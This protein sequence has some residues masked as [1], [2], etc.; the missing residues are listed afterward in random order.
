MADD[1]KIEKRRNELRERSRKKAEERTVITDPGSIQRSLGLDPSVPTVPLPPPGAKAVPTED[2]ASTGLPED[3]AGPYLS[4]PASAEERTSGRR[5]R[6]R[7]RFKP[8]FFVILLALIVIIIAVIRAAGSSSSN[9][10]VRMTD[11]G[12]THASRYANCAVINGIDVSQ[13]QGTGIN[14]KQ[15]KTSGADFVFIRAGFRDAEDGSLNKDEN[16][17]TN[18]K[19]ASKAGLM[20]GAYFYSQALTP[21]EAREEADYLTDLVSNY[22]I[23][24]PLVIDYEIYPGGR[25]EQKIDAGELYAASFYH[26]IVIAFCREVEASGYESAVYANL[27]MFTNYMDAGLLQDS[28]TLWLARYNETADL[29]ANYMF[30][31]CSNSA[32][33][34]G[35]EGDVDHDFWYIEPGKVYKT[36]G[37]SDTDKTRI[38]V[39]NCRI[40]FQRTVTKVKN[41]RAIPKLGVTY[42]GEALKEGRDYTISYVHNTEPGTGYVILKGIGLFKNWMAVP[43]STE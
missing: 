43:Y 9:T 17:D 29:D 22:D 40:S 16:F 36:R 27:D 10:D 33:A 18:I 28:A 5:K 21:K 38:S 4:V 32:Q 12:F 39:G 26:D 30:W 19:G 41:H 8:R 3:T 37:A 24:L 42:E 15:A 20:V 35:I 6:S 34:G 2:T 1:S 23:T 31:Q 14:W 7:F 11:E 25:L 13:H